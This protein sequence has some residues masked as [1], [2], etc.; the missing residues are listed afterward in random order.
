M[1]E[2]NFDIFA[3]DIGTRTVVGLLLSDEN[4]EYHVKDS[5]V[6]TH[7][8][9]AMFDGQIHD[10]SSVT[11]MADNIISSLEDKNGIKIDEA[12]VAAAGRALETVECTREIEFSTRRKI[13][14]EDV[15]ALEYS[16]IQKARDTL[17]RDASGDEDMD[18]HFVGHTVREY[19]VDD[20]FLT[21]I[22][23][24]QGRKISADIIATFLPRIVVDSLLSVLNNIDLEVMGLTLEPIAASEVVVPPSMYNFNLALVDIGAG[25]ADIAITRG[26]SMVGYGMV[27]VAGD[28]ITETIAEEFLIDYY[29]AEK[30][31][32]SLREE[33][34]FEVKDALSNAVKISADEVL[35]VIEDSVSEMAGLIAEEILRLN[36][37]PPRAVICIGGGSLTPGFTEKLSSYLE[38]NEDR[39]G[40][41]DV[42]D[43]EEV[44]GEIDTLSGAQMITPLGIA[45]SAD[46]RRE[47]AVFLQVEVNN[48][49]VSLFSL[50][51]PGVKDALLQADVD[52]ESLSPSPGRGITY[53]LNGEVRSIPGSLGKPG[54]VKLNG[55][56]VELEKEVNDGDIIEFEPGERGEDAEAKIADVLPENPGEEIEINFEGEILELVPLLKANGRRI[57]PEEKLKDGMDIE[58]KPLNTVGDALDKILEIDLNEQKN[59]FIEVSIDG[60]KQYLPR[61]NIAVTDGKEPVSLQKQLVQGQ[62]LSLDRS[63]PIETAGDLLEKIIDHGSGV[64]FNFNGNELEVPGNINRIEVNGTEVSGD[65]RLEEGDEVKL[66]SGEITVDH[67]LEY[68]NYGLSPRMKEEVTLLINGEEKDFDCSISQGDKIELKFSREG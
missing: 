19:R 58:Y 63:G 7:E 64:S 60:E 34:N 16:A 44:K 2:E 13:T 1:A 47:E 51:K 35:A 5:E 25:T 10:V 26:G 17:Q 32:C 20:I 40:I 48:S 66:I 3:L 62:K 65:Y 68:I 23:H 4:G 12:A 22:L 53:S 11:D 33:D 55:E 14:S 56:E 37:N 59:E 24:Q 8:D 29:T 54:T 21:E 28:E 52:L 18:Y 27:P 45:V 61:S 67:V 30:I 46:R 49:T 9:R 43:V 36:Q 31:K 42:N 6:L 57:D 39:V 50:Q 41:R 38:L 15:Q